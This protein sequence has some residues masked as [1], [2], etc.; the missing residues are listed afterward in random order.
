MPRP[1]ETKSE[2]D[3]RGAFIR[4]P[5][6]FIKPFGDDPDDNHAESGRYAIYWAHGC[7]WSNRP[8]IAR[9]ILGLQD[10]IAD[11]ATTSTGIKNIYGHG[12]ADQPDHRDPICGAYF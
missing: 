2:I 12:F 1:K 6:A 4:Q 9:D 7:H 3:E 5:N 8:V 10:V 11:V